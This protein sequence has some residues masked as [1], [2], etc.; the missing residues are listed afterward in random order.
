[1]WGLGG[2]KE[3]RWLSGRGALC[4][5]GAGR[6]SS[7]GRPAV[8]A[9]SRRYDYFLAGFPAAHVVRSLIGLDGLVHGMFFDLGILSG[10]SDDLRVL[11][12]GRWRSV[13]FLFGE[14]RGIW[15]RTPVFFPGFSCGSCEDFDAYLEKI[16]LILA[17][18]MHAG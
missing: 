11:V 17:A 5:L 8:A 15:L 13:S 4:A 1:M 9:A 3:W 14:S 2:S 7:S 18:E 12:L 10:T 6:R 16:L